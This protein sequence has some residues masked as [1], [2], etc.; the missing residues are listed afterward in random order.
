MLKNWLK[1]FSEFKIDINITSNTIGNDSKAMTPI[2]PIITLKTGF[3]KDRLKG[4]F[5]K[6]RSSENKNDPNW[7]RIIDKIDII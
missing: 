1:T 6:I 2:I 5:H 4:I 3:S 7:E